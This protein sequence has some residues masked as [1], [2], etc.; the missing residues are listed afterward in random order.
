MGPSSPSD[1]EDEDGKR[2]YAVLQLRRENEEGTLLGLVGCQTNLKFGEQKRVFSLIPALRN[3]EFVRYGVMHRN[4][5]LD[6]PHVL[7]QIFRQK[8]IQTSF[9]RDR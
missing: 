9:L 1:L 7:S 5:F 8:T 2:P 6:S 4:T 3:A